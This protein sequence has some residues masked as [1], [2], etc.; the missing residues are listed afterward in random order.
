MYLLGLGELKDPRLFCKA[1]VYKHRK[2]VEQSKVQIRKIIQTFYMIQFSQFPLS[3]WTYGLGLVRSVSVSKYGY[4]TCTCIQLSSLLFHKHVR[5]LRNDATGLIYNYVLLPLG[6]VSILNFINSYQK[7][8]SK[9]EYKNKIN[10]MIAQ[11]SILLFYTIASGQEVLVT[12][13][14]RN[15]TAQPSPSP[16]VREGF[17]FLLPWKE[18]DEE[19]L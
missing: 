16:K 7:L 1:S 9:S 8:K 2:K 15:C 13:L 14:Y 11:N 5:A 4:Y 6:I 12:P 3:I 10:T 19:K 18:K 17:F